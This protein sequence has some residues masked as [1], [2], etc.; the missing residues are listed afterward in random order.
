MAKLYPAHEGHLPV[1][2]E[3]NVYLNG[4]KAWE[5]EKNGLTVSEKVKVDLV[6]FWEKPL[7]RKNLLKILTER[8][9]S[10]TWIISVVIVELVSCPVPSRQKKTQRKNYI[11]FTGCLAALGSP[12]YISR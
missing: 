7:S 8:R 9:F 6:E 1:W 5:H 3:G 4:A 10:L 12:F 11:E 2:S